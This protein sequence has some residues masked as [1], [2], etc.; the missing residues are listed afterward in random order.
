[1][2]AALETVC[3]LIL[4]LKWTVMFLIIHNY[5]L[6][7]K[8]PGSLVK[9]KYEQFDNISISLIHSGI[10]AIGSL[11]ILVQEPEITQ[12]NLQSFSPLS[13]EFIKFTYGYMV[14]DWLDM[15]R[16][17]EWN[18]KNLKEMTVH[19]LCVISGCMTAIIYRQYTS[20]GMVVMI[21]EV[22]SVFLHARAL[23][24]Y[25]G[26]RKKTLFKTMAIL[27]ILTNIVFRI[28]TNYV[29]YNWSQT[30][31]KDFLLG[32]L[33]NYLIFA[34]NIKLLGQLIVSDFIRGTE[35]VWKC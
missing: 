31:G 22:N 9:R 17:A 18:V 21:M 33:S 23:M 1:M 32:K 15:L 30:E 26:L 34:L 20:F 24:Q 10:T 13:L 35:Q 25:C 6:P 16:M 8:R 3:E 2:V 14:Y 19:H 27:N 5:I 29:L 28:G 7:L 11:Y 4:P 12:L